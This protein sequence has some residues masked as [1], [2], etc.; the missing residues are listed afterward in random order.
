MTLILSPVLPPPPVSDPETA[1]LGRLIQ[2]VMDGLAKPSGWLPSTVE[3]LG[4]KFIDSIIGTDVLPDGRLGATRVRYGMALRDKSGATLVCIR[5]TAGVLEWIEDCEFQSM[6]HPSGQGWVEAGFW[7]VYQSLKLGGLPLAQGLRSVPGEILV[8]GHSL[9]APLACYAG[10]DLEGAK[11]RALAS[12]KP[13]SG[14]FGAYFDLMVKDYRGWNYSP[15]MVPHLPLSVMGYRDLP[16]VQ[17]FRP[18]EAQVR[19]RDGS[20]ECRHSLLAYCQRLDFQPGLP[21]GDCV[22]GKQGDG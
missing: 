18:S 3:A 2:L 9:G 21:G 22:L 13:G 14:A 4:Y 15:D 20:V 12:P 6:V 17:Y 7:Q 8:A 10:V 16:R 5:G 19:T 1:Q 11:V